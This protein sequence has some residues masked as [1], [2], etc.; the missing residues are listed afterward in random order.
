MFL[1]TKL[2]FILPKFVTIG[3]LLS[4]IKLSTPWLVTSFL[5]PRRLLAELFIVSIWNIMRVR[6]W[7]SFIW[8]SFVIFALFTIESANRSLVKN[9]SFPILQ[10]VKYL[11]RLSIMNY[12]FFIAIIS[13]LILVSA[14]GIDL[15]LVKDTSDLLMCPQES[16]RQGH[17]CH[18]C[19]YLLK[20]NQ[21]SN[22]LGY[23]L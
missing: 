2:S 19:L 6:G 12:S 1:L 4:E 22:F 15:I 3:L 13:T 23:S 18:L 20:L 11:H 8:I 14:F 17:I 21:V 7:G 16:S 10:W 5:F 9:G